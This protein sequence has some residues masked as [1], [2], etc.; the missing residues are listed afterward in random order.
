[1]RTEAAFLCE[2]RGWKLEALQARGS[3]HVSS[4]KPSRSNLVW[5]KLQKYEK[6]SVLKSTDC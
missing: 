2:A 6:N 3:V 1:M 4:S 5:D